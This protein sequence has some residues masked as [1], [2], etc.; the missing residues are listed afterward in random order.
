MST[1]VRTEEFQLSAPENWDGSE[2]SLGELST[3]GSIEIEII[4]ATANHLTQV[5]RDTESLDQVMAELGDNKI[6]DFF[7]K[8]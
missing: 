5:E 2:D 7:K 8:D 3:C 4:E 1:N 6:E